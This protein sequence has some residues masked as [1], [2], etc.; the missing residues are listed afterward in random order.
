VWKEFS[1]AKEQLQHNPRNLTVYVD[2]KTGRSLSNQEGFCPGG[3]RAWPSSGYFDF[4]N[5][6]WTPGGGETGVGKAS[7]NMTL[8]GQKI[9]QN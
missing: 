3:G 8:K 9:L 6:P 5:N 2:P 4:N 1:P 7:K